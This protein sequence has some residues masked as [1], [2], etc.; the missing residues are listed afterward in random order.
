MAEKAAE[1]LGDLKRINTCF[2]GVLAVLDV[3]TIAHRH[4]KKLGLHAEDLSK[5]QPAEVEAQVEEG[6]TRVPLY[7]K[8]C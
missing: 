4:S 7:L 6:F 1:R 2:E 8:S 5:I 3:S